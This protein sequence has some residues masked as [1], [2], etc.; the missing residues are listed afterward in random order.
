MEPL[1]DPS[2]LSKE[3]TPDYIPAS[4]AEIH[5]MLKQVGS[6]QLDD[7]FSHISEEFKFTQAPWYG[8]DLYM[9]YTDLIHHFEEM[10]KKNSIK[11][12][13]IGDG[14]K[15]YAL[16]PICSEVAKIRGLTTAYTPYQPERSQGTLTSLWLYSNALSALTGF[17]AINASLY[18]RS[19]CLYEAVVTAQKN[20]RQKGQ[21]RAVFCEP[22]YPGDREVLETMAQETNLTFTFL[23]PWDLTSLE[24]ELGE[25]V[26]CLIYSQVNALGL[27]EDVDALTN[28]AQKK[29]LQTIAIID[30]IHLAS[31]GLKPPCQ[32]GD[33]GGPDMIVG[34][35]QHLALGPNFGGPGL[36]IFGIRFPGRDKK[37]IRNSPGRLIGATVDRKGRPCQSIVL[38]TREQH[39]R[40]EKAT[41]NICSNQ[42]FIAT[43]AGASLLAQGDRGLS[44]TLVITRQR[45]V[46]LSEELINTYQGLSLSYPQGA[47]WNEFVLNLG[48]DCDQFIEEARQAKLHIGV[49]ASKRVGDGRNF[50]LMI[51]CNDLQKES[52]IKDIITFFGTQYATKKPGAKKISAPPLPPHLLRTLPV[53]L[54][55]YPES[56]LIDYYRKLGEQNV[57][58]DDTIYPLGSC[59][60]KYN[61][62]VND[63]TASLEGFA[64]VHPQAP[65]MDCQGSLQ[66][67][68]E[69]QEF[70]K[71]ITGLPAVTTQPVAGAQGELV[72]L[73]MFQAYHRDRGN[74]HR[75]V[76]LIPKSAHGTNP[77]SAT[78]AGFSSIVYVD[79]QDDGLIDLLQLKELIKEHK[80]NLCGMMMTN[81]NTSGVFEEHFAKIAKLIS[82]AGGLV[83]MDGANMNAIAS[84]VNLESLGVD[85]VHNNLHKTWT[86]PHGGG[87]P[88]DAIVA[89]SEKI[90][91]YLPGVQV[92]LKDG[93]YYT[94]QTSQSIGQ[95]HRHY[96]N[97]AHK[98]R[99]LTYLKRLGRE[100]IRRM[101]GVAT[102]NSRYLYHHLKK[103]YHTLPKNPSRPVM[104]EFIL[105]LSKEEFATIQAIGIPK[106]QIIPR[107]GKLF[108]DYGLH[109]PT[110]AF[111]EQYGLM[112]EPTE[113]FDQKDLD[114]FIAVAKS[115]KKIITQHPEVLKTTPH[116]TPIDRVDEATANRELKLHGN[117]DQLPI[118][119]P[120]RI[121]PQVLGQMS[122][123]DISQKIVESCQM[124]KIS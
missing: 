119:I 11:P 31:K 74:P 52:D 42:S 92:G 124:E 35:G 46:S 112:V 120:N 73:K 50:H 62:L 99:A 117:L 104:H 14:L 3:L 80:E 118:I 39:I 5:N 26:F 90:K 110:V 113:S 29:N 88:G 28:L 12:S 68:Y 61:P 17:E 97:F 109:A 87:G 81:P 43:L 71:A 58:P 65:L 10:A 76:L 48:R 27:L 78:V 7:L 108:L 93:E 67:L 40:R 98:V 85:A 122:V 2:P 32:F 84:W 23:D 66:V 22:L 41:S 86:I 55:H 107:L 89:V 101:S 19:T 94:Y 60:M 116:F 111:P 44:Q 83:Y 121:S 21:K 18:D 82:Q 8:D 45:A 36:G 15:S 63:Y 33:H 102:L 34:E 49:N 51:F 115:I 57:S 56:E 72:G 70:F 54:P 64:N 123:E 13:F 95:F 79:A 53:K 16:P 37:A 77:A 1:H 103:S 105:T 59:T 30:P 25:D 38:S 24:R 47:F 75:N 106:A 6:S 9:T 69:I 91:D 4:E 96:G 100:G 114:R 20:Q